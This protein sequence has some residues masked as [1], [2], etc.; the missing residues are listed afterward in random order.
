MLLSFN[1]SQIKMFRLLRRVVQRIIE[2]IRKVEVLI[3][4]VVTVQRRGTIHSINYK[5]SK[6]TMRNLRRRTTIQSLYEVRKL[7]W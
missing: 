4:N 2:K 7:L 1:F 6:D 3:V 5:P